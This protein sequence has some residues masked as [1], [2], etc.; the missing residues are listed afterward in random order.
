MTQ[1]VPVE[2]LFEFIN[3]FKIALDLDD[4]ACAMLKTMKFATENEKHIYEIK[5]EGDFQQK[6]GYLVSISPIF[7]E[8]LL[9]SQILKAQKRLTT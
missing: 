3:A 9:P 6:Y 4:N 7:Y 8:E 5:Y 1:G 2:N